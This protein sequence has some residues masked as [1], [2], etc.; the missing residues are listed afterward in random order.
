MNPIDVT[1]WTTLLVALSPLLVALIRRPSLSDTQV[2][3]L[4]VVVVGV[5]FFAGRALD[6]VLMW[7]LPSSLATEFAAALLLQQGVYQLLRK[8]PL[9]QSLEGADL[10]P[11]GRRL[12]SI[13]FVTI[14]TTT[15]MR[16]LEVVRWGR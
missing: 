5:V 8:T 9:L 15:A 16:L 14:S 2:S 3:A 1:N 10:P 7:P 11:P 12:M 13:L 6:G 4:T